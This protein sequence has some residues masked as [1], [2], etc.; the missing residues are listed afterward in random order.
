MS[1]Q[2]DAQAL[3]DSLLKRAKL[4][5]EEERQLAEHECQR[6][7]ESARL[8][9][10]QRRQ[11]IE[12]QARQQA[13]RHYRQQVQRA[14][15][16]Q[17]SKLE[18]LRWTLV[19][20]V[21]ASLADELRQLAERPAD[22]RALLVALL[23]EG[24]QAIEGEQ[25]VAQLN[26]R[27]LSHYQAEWPQLLTEAGCDKTVTLSDDKCE[28]SGGVLLYNVTNDIR[29]DNTFEGRLAR[30]RPVLQQTI[31]EHLFS[32]IDSDRMVSNAG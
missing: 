7:L 18:Q 6:L 24:C 23:H 14:E 27:D 25:L 2:D 16:A 5:A 21:Y 11:Q 3:E 4:L 1:E 28:C 17:I 29:Y 19:E 8:R 22:Y 26:N 31:G 20:S 13:E 12:A 15:L 32:G 10:E 30:L 9:L